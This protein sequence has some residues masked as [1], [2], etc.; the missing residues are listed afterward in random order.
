MST[1]VL[2][3]GGEALIDAEDIQKVSAHKW[4]KSFQGYAVASKGL[5]MHRLVMDT[6]S[7]KY[8]D[9]VNKD[10]LDNRKSNLRVCSQSENMGNSKKRSD[11]SS[12]YKGVSF[13][14]SRKNWEA[15][16]NKGGKR[17]KLGY[18]KTAELAAL[19]Y[20]NKAVELYGDFASLNNI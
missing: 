15:Y 10:N 20:N 6:P 16:I 7:Q 14:S 18:H 11:N 9:H 2:L 19:A 13:Y 3:N 12:G 17:I 8:T 1:I 5:L 4:Y